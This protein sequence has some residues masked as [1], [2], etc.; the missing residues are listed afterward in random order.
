MGV[1]KLGEEYDENDI[2][3]KINAVCDKTDTSL[4]PTVR[5]YQNRMISREK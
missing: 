1:K 2:I 5:Q 3:A 4:N